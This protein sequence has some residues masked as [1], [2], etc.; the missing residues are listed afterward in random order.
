MEQNHN[1]EKMQ[2]EPTTAAIAAN[3]MLAA[4]LSGGGNEL[5]ANFMENPMIILPQMLEYNTSWD[6]LIP[7]IEKIESL[8]IGHGQMR[9]KIERTHCQISDRGGYYAMN[10]DLKKDYQLGGACFSNNYTKIENTY[11]MVVEFIKWHNEW[12]VSKGGS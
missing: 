2:I 4:A 5:I 8:W 9:C 12:S 6:W 10:S 11:R 1:N 7:V 3:L